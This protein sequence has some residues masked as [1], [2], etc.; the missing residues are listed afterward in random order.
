LKSTLYVLATE[1]WHTRFS[2]VVKVLN[3]M[4]R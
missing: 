1:M 3:L 4:G 2:Q